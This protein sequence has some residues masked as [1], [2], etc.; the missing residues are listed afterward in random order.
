MASKDPVDRDAAYWRTFRKFG[1]GNCSSTREKISSGSVTL[2][3]RI[4]SKMSNER[5]EATGVRRRDSS[6]PLKMASLGEAKTA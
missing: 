3:A 1:H 6:L 2:R 4:V 5:T